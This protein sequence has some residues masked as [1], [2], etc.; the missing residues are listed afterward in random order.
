[1]E[2]LELEADQHLF[3]VLYLHSWKIDEIESP[4]DQIF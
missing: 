2:W 4:N 1:M 3:L